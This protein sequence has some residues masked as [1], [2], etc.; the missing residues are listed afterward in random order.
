VD[1]GVWGVVES[2][3]K[4]PREGSFREALISFYLLLPV[5]V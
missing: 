3:V 1:A 2:I 4:T 5:N